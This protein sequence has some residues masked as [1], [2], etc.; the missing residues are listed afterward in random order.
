MAVEKRAKP[1]AGKPMQERRLSF[2][3]LAAA[4]AAT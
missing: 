2:T 1:A 4:Q 3:R